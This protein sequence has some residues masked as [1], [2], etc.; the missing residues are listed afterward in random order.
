MQIPGHSTNWT[1]FLGQ[2][3]KYLH[4]YKTWEWCGQW[5]GE[6]HGLEFGLTYPVTPP[7]KYDHLE[8]Q[9]S[10]LPRDSICGHNC[11]WAWWF[12]T[13][14]WRCLELS[15][16][17]SKHGRSSWRD[18]AFGTYFSQP[19]L[20][21]QACFSCVF[22][23]ILDNVSYLRYAGDSL[24]LSPWPVVLRVL[25]EPSLLT[26]TFLPTASHRLLTLWG[27]RQH[28]STTAKGHSQEYSEMQKSVAIKELW[29]MHFL[30]EETRRQSYLLLFPPV[31]N[32]ATQFFFLL[33][34]Y[35]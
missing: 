25:P 29:K 12:T 2:D 18:Q 28:F 33:Q 6:S 8:P 21:F 32:Q 9:N 34:A 1:H 14:F 16:S 19:I 15:C 26:I 17:S 13:Q 5:V 24:A 22:L 4:S 3:L 10:S 31:V 20:S 27:H 35:L 7:H 23:F 30:T 11:R